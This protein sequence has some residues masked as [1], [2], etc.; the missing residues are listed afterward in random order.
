VKNNLKWTGE[1]LVTEVANEDTIYHLH[2]YAI[3]MDY[4]TGKIVVD[5]ASGEGYRSNLM[6]LKAKHV[7]GIDISEEAVL[8]AAEKYNTTTNLSFKVGS[9]EKIPLDDHMADVV[10]SF[11][12]L[13]H[14]DKHH[15][16]MRE[17]KRVLKPGGIVII[18]SPD[19]ANYSDRFN[20]VNSFHVKELYFI[21][22][23]ELLNQYFKTSYFYY[24][25]FLTGS[26]IVKDNYTNNTITEYTGDYLAIAAN[27]GLSFPMF[28]ISVSSD[29]P[30]N[31]PQTSYFNGEDIIRDMYFKRV[32]SFTPYRLGESILKPLRIF[33][34]FFKRS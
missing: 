32:M 15:E 28:N 14:T 7:Y 5:I 18:S 31:E 21:E 12:T 29:E 17:V 23:K 6:A 33:K 24:Q 19:K 20:R 16:M 1:R 9:V 27:N 30:F 10:V 8:F 34:N 26:L 25:T 4:I 3:P 13:E 2:R 22:F 11:E